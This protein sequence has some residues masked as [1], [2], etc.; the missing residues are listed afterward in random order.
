MRK[1]MYGLIIFLLSACAQQQ[2]ESKSAPAEA[3]ENVEYNTLLDAENDKEEVPVSERGADSFKV[4]EY[5]NSVRNDSVHAEI[6]AN[7]ALRSDS[8]SIMNGLGYYADWDSMPI[9]WATTPSVD[10]NGQVR[11][12]SLGYKSGETSFNYSIGDG[13]VS[14]N[15]SQFD[16]NENHFDPEVL[17]EVLSP[18]DEKAL[19]HINDLVDYATILSDP[20][21]EDVF[22]DKAEELIGKLLTRDAVVMINGTK[23]T[24]KDAVHNQQVLSEVK[25]LLDHAPIFTQLIFS[26]G[27]KGN[28]VYPISQ[29]ENRFVS[30]HYR[31]VARKKW[32]GRKS[33]TV[34]QIL[35]D[36]IEIQ[37][38]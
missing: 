27:E 5:R 17:H 12:D 34:E 15:F 28:V 21:Q 8:L 30:I 26:N 37:N 11:T 7:G 32:F 18:F 29:D 4:G 31:K 14:A 33:K 3:S 24:W 19:E 16:K 20:E 13:S 10:R 25:K 6:E 36:T 1:W 22:R 35:I 9:S 23:H 38:Q 2:S